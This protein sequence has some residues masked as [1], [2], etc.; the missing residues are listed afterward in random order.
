M[1][2]M[3][4]FNLP[5][6]PHPLR[7]CYTLQ[8]YA[9]KNENSPWKWF[10]QRPFVAALIKRLKQERGALGVAS[11]GRALSDELAILLSCFLSKSFL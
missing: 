6:C 3:I 4:A 1:L 9:T 5:G 7:L 8:E 11:A 10:R 2:E